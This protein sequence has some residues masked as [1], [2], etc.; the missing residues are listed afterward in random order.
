ML[1]R[2]CCGHKP[3]NW[4]F[5]TRAVSVVLGRRSCGTPSARHRRQANGRGSTP[6]ILIFQNN[7]IES[8]PRAHFAPHSDQAPPQKPQPTTPSE[9]PSRTGKIRLQAFTTQTF[10]V[11]LAD[12]STLRPCLRQGHTQVHEASFLHQASYAGPTNP[13]ISGSLSPRRTTERT[14]ETHRGDA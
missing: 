1:L 13:Q 10:A 2:V 3:A 4:G 12:S 8:I 7:S 14:T 11:E 6:D 9:T 5:S